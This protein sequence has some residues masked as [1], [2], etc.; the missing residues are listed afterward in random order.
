MSRSKIDF[1]IQQLNSNEVRRPRWQGRSHRTER[2]WLQTP[3]EAR[4]KI[5][6]FSCL[7]SII[8]FFIKIYLIPKSHTNKTWQTT[9]TPKRWIFIIYWLIKQT[10]VKKPAWQKEAICPLSGFEPTV[11]QSWSMIEQK[12]LW[13][14]CHSEVLCDKIIVQAGRVV[15][16][17]FWN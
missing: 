15:P 13:P 14:R 12:R 3:V 8:L 7:S 6:I 10:K 2:C 1:K 9:K 4:K 11:F 17:F 5:N 16:V